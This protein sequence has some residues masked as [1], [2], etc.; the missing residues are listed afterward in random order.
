[1]S[2]DV[3]V[4][5]EEEIMTKSQLIVEIISKRKLYNSMVGTLY[6]PMV[7][8]EIVDLDKRLMLVSGRAFFSFTE[9]ERLDA[10]AE[11]ELLT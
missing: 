1:M 2:A 4:P 3:A 7:E 5:Q 8:K 6:P 11:V 9:Q 10:L